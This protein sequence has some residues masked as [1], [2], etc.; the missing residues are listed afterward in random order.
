MDNAGYIS[1]TRQSGLLKEMQTVANN[2]ANISTTG[3]QREGVVFSE[4]IERGGATGDSMSFADAH[5]RL[6]DRSQGMLANTGGAFDFAIEGPGYFLLAT[7]NGERLTRAGSFTPDNQSELVSNDGYKVLDIGGAPIFIPPNAKS[8]AVASDG[9]IS[10]D[11]APL[12]QIGVVVPDDPNKM[13]RTSGVMFRPE[14]S[15]QPIDKPVIS[16]GFIEQSNVDPVL[17][18]TRMIEVQR[19]YELSQKFIEREDERIRSVVRVLGQ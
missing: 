8:I 10:A 12:T 16:Q 2:I 9:T 11:G 15:Y 3:Y 13:I 14:G 5:G 19:T 18:M 6:T 1:L 17:E 4:F 7:P